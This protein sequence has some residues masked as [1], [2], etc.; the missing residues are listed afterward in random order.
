MTDYPPVPPPPHATAQ[1]Y[2]PPQRPGIGGG[3]VAG[4]VLVS[5]W[6][7]LSIFFS[8]FLIP[9]GADATCN[10]EADLEA[11]L[12]RVT[13]LWLVLLGIELAAVVGT[14]I[15]WVRPRTRIW[16]FLLGI[17]GTGV[18]ALVFTAIIGINL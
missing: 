7:A 18:L 4:I 3:T 16:G 14:I 11:C 17:L 5:I 9:F 8:V 1:P 13:V 12:D 15:L 2:P 10:A 6:M